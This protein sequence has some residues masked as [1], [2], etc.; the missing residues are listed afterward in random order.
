MYPLRTVIDVR[1]WQIRTSAG[2]ATINSS[3][4]PDTFVLIRRTDLTGPFTLNDTTDSIT[5]Y[6]NSLIKDGLGYRNSRPG[7]FASASRFNQRFTL[8]DT[9]QVVRTYTDLTPTFGSAN[10]D[11]G[12]ISG[13]VRD[14]NS[15]LLE[16]AL[17]EARGLIDEATTWSRYNP[18]T[19]QYYLHGLSRCKYWMRATK[20]GYSPTI[21]P[22]SVGVGSRIDFV[23]YTISAEEERLTSPGVKQRTPSLFVREMRLRYDP[24]AKMEI[25]NI[26]GNKIS[27]LTELR[28]LTPGIYFVVMNKKGAVT[29]HKIVFIR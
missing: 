2:L 5:L 15:N 8:P 28:N 27:R 19:G 11:Y 25:Y 14:E 26:A 7:P 24:E 4:L 22:D 9:Q 6:Q 10:D 3:V 23:L 29:S 1:G 13:M 21:Y 12:S 17:I 18:Y 20:P 16:G